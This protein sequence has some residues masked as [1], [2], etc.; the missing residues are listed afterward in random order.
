[1]FF[2]EILN[3]RQKEGQKPIQVDYRW[4]SLKKCGPMDLRYLIDHIASKDRDCHI[5]T[6]V[7]GKM[8]EGK[9]EFAWEESGGDQLRQ[10]VENAVWHFTGAF[11]KDGE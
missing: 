11:D 7:H 10:D 4:T 8:V 5:N 2:P 1:M 3:I 9:F 6:G